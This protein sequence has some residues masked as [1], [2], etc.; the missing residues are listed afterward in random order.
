MS[1]ITLTL[2]AVALLSVPAIPLA[3]ADETKADCE[4]G[5]QW[6]GYTST[7]G[8]RG[9]VGS[10][11][12]ANTVR[13]CEGEH[14]DGQDSVQP[15]Q[16]PGNGAGCN[17]A[18][19]VLSPNS[20]FL[21]SCM[22]P[23]PNNGGADPLSGNGQP[24]VFRVSYLNAG[25]KT[26][27]AYIALDIA[28]VGRTAVYNGECQRGDTGI[29]GNSACQGSGQSRTGVYL[30]DNTPGNILAQA[31]SAPGITKGHVAESDCDQ[32]TYAK[33][34]NTNNRDL[35]GRD[36]TAITVDSILP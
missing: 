12:G 35:C 8:L 5:Q 16:N 23:D 6:A 3:M 1:K 7:D 25:G 10:I 19:N 36:N 18:Q 14:W 21:G 24:V 22:S 31:V 11:I 2:I 33:G 26:Q 29:E 15:A 34:A 4:P 9:L 28:L 32:A 27:E 30:R 20:I 17:K 13:P